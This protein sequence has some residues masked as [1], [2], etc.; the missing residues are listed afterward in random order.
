MPAGRAAFQLT[1]PEPP[2]HE[3]QID[4][5]TMLQTVL[6]PNVCWTAIDHGHT[7]DMRPG[8]RGVPI[9]LLEARKRKARGVRA[10]VPDYLFW[11]RAHSFAIELKTIDGDTSDDQKKFLREMISAEV[12]I[13]ICRT[14]T[15]VFY[16]VREWGLTRPMR[17]SA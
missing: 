16:K 6:L 8:R 14:I 1:T 11:H 12:E 13:A 7:F 2:E 3:L 17:V 10:G 4:C 15:S 9:G 5:T